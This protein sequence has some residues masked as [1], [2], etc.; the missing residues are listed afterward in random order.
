ME[1]DGEFWHGFDWEHERERIKTNRDYWIPK[2]EAN[3]E[4]DRRED[5]EL[6]AL[7]WTVVRFWSME[8]EK[9]LDGCVEA[10]QEMVFE[11]MMENK[12]RE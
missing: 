9:N 6:E 1:V 5:A 11:R 2:I 3:I 7:G 12:E 8:V 4:R 10:V